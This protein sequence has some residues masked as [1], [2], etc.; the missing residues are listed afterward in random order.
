MR[1][2]RTSTVG[3]K[4]WEFYCT[5]SLRREAL[6]RKRLEPKFLFRY[7][8]VCIRICILIRIRLEGQNTSEFQV[9]LGHLDN[10][11][12]ELPSITVESWS[13]LLRWADEYCGKALRK[14]CEAFLLA[15]PAGDLEALKTAV[16]YKIR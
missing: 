3:A 6:E 13:W 2:R 12:A 1:T 9:F 14:R 7:A 5:R 11:A 16:Q 4:P 15:Q 8:Y 10:G